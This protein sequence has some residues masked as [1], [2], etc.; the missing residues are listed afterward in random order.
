MPLK[1]TAPL[2]HGLESAKKHIFSLSWPVT[3][4]WNFCTLKSFSIFWL[5]WQSLRFCL[6]GKKNLPWNFHAVSSHYL[7]LLII[8]FAMCSL[9]SSGTIYKM[10]FHSGF[11]VHLLSRLLQESPNQL[12]PSCASG[13]LLAITM[14]SQAIIKVTAFPYCESS[15]NEEQEGTDILTQF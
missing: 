13:L 3:F 9:S 1:S 12:L 7:L 6:W 2:P 15:F 8:V 4:L 10:T 5:H 11:K 14:A